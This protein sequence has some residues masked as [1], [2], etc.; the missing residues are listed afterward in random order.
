MST[1]PDLRFFSADPFSGDYLQAL[2]ADLEQ[3]TWVRFLV[4]YFNQDGHKALAPHLGNALRHPLSRGLVTL[5]CACGLA[6]LRTLKL[7]ANPA[8]D[9]LRV[10]LPMQS[11][12]PAE[13]RLLHSKMAVIVRPGSS[14]GAP[15]RVVLYTGSHN[16]TGPGLRAAD[17]GPKNVEASVRVE[18][19][20]N[21]DWLP[22][23]GCAY[24]GGHPIAD[25]LA[26]M[27]RAFHLAS[28]TD[29]TSA[30]AEV[31]LQSWLRA[32]CRFDLASPGSSTFVVATAVLG[33]QVDGTTARSGKK[34]P[35]RPPYDLPRAGQRLF[36]QHYNVEG[37]EPE[38]FDAAT[39]WALLVWGRS[40]D[41]EQALVPWLILCRPQAVG[42]RNFGSPNLQAVDW[43]LYDAKHNGPAGDVQRGV[44]KTKPDSHT[45]QATTSVAGRGL[46]VAHWRLAP[47]AAGVQTKDLNYTE[48]AR[49]VLLEVIVV[50]RP[51]APSEGQEAS[52]WEGSELVFDHGRQRARR[53]TWIV[54]DPD[55]RPD[56]DR[57]RNMRKEQKDDLGLEVDDSSA[58]T[59]QVD[60]LDADLADADV[61]LCKAPVNLVL[62]ARAGALRREVAGE[63]GKARRV[64]LEASSGP[65]PSSAPDK[66]D[67]Q[68]MQK[69]VGPGATHFREVLKLTDQE[70][71]RLRLVPRAKGK[72]SP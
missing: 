58:P 20:W 42:R 69:L 57:A 55:G 2:R 43:L 25:A 71:V 53:V 46:K 31:E 63:P 52:T 61:Y 40:A 15:D 37:K 66:A 56:P 26:H 10:F 34:V 23:A 30:K 5:T 11:E 38:T 4:C 72:A 65:L 68:R 45:V 14:P 1:V 24:Y 6:G 36:V 22:E 21:P 47:V 39:P 27:D 33:G 48:P 64:I 28:C 3:A 16:W 35:R 62:M 41:L 12:G 50:R 13:T 59:G 17:K 18:M 67:V 8:R 44:A 60:L 49:Y 9:Q 32:H 54:H 70:L 51:R 7:E 29:M 19:D